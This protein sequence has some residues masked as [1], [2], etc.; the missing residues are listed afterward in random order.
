[1]DTN[2]LIQNMI[3]AAKLDVNFFNAVEHDESK[4]QEALTVVIIAGVASAIGNGIL[5]VFSSGLIAGLI[6]AIFGLGMMV[7]GYYIWSYLTFY[8]GTK[9]FGGEADVGE[10]LRTFGYAYSPQVLSILA[11]IPCIGQMAAFA[12]G[13]WSLVA[14]V[15]ALREAMDFDTTKAIITAVIAWVILWIVFG[16]IIGLLAVM[17]LGGA[18]GFSALLG[19]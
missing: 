14:G 5:G 13:I 3:S 18:F 17:G 12:G 8:I 19:Q 6:G 9:F 4:N 1:M 7:L 10:V 11:F 16:V 2:S 15:I